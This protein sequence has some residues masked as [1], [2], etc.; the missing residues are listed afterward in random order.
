MTKL[1]KSLLEVEGKIIVCCPGSA[2][3]GGPELLHQLVHE[4]RKLNHDAY[5]LYYQFDKKH[6]CPIPYRKYNAPQTDYVDTS[7]DIVFIPENATKLMKYFKKARL[8]IWWLSIDNY[9]G[10]RRESKIKDFIKKYKRI[11]RKR[12]PLWSLKGYLHF[13]QSEYARIFLKNYG[14]ESIMLTDYLSSEHLTEKSVN[15][16]RKDIIVYNPSKG[17]KTTKKLIERNKDMVFVP[18]VGMSHNEVKTLLESAKI[19][20]DFGHHPGKDRI[21]REAAM[22]G[23]CVITGLKGSAKNNCDLPIPK[24]YKLDESS[25]KFQELFRQIATSV[26]IEYENHL[27]EF[28]KYRE[29]I[30]GEPETFRTQVINIF[31]TK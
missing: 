20:I 23:C 28:D 27:V 1:E 9:F 12:L 19:Y 6:E 30:R 3:T 29:K 31:G 8:A 24:K 15:K 22:A 2:V 14:I 13:T 5:I 21:P 18:L 26:F 17:A 11:Y 16:S 7:K 4:L 25:S 10:I